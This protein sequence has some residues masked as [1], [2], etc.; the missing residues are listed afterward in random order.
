MGAAMATG[1]GG[2]RLLYILFW[3]RRELKSGIGCERRLHAEQYQQQEFA[4]G[5]NV[6]LGIEI[7]H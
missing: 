5:S 4:D 2:G 1:R 6:A 7:K 3:L